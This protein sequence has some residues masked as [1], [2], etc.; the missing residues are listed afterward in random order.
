MILVVV[1][2]VPALLFG[3]WNVG[4]FHFLSQGTLAEKGF[5]DIFFYGFLRVLPIIIVSYVTGLTIEVIFAQIRNHDVPEGL[6][7]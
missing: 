6:R 1:A 2:M 3:M 4:H 7:I 5:W